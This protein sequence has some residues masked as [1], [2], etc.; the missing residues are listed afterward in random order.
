MVVNL[1]KNNWDFDFWFWG[2]PELWEFFF[3]SQGLC[4]QGYSFPPPF[5]RYPHLH[6]LKSDKSDIDSY[7]YHGYHY[8]SFKWPTTIAYHNGQC[9]GTIVTVCR[10]GIVGVPALDSNVAWQIMTLEL[11]QERL[12][13]IAAKEFEKQFRSICHLGPAIFEDM[14]RGRSP[15]KK[16]AT[17]PPTIV[18][19]TSGPLMPLNLAPL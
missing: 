17:A 8:H 5:A 1:Y 9:Y 11:V 18:P 6:A 10:P 4:N 15:I 19:P 3:L 2:V 13:N 12:D 14:K 7:H 16:K